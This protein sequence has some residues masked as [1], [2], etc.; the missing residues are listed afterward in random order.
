M[1]NGKKGTILAYRLIPKSLLSR[2]FGSLTRVPLPGGLID[3]IISWYSRKY[4]I[5]DEY[6]TP[7]GGFRTVNEF[8][9]RELRPGS[10]K[11]D[12]S[13]GALVSPVDARVDQFGRITE[14]AVI[15]A[16][17]LDYPA[18]ELVPSEMSRRL[19]K[20]S[21]ITLYLSPG[22]YHRIHSPVQGSIAGFFSIPGTLFTVQDFMVRGLPGLFV[23]NERL[24]TYIE[25][26]NG[27]ISVCKIG[28]M[29]VG[30]ISLSY[31]LPGEKPVITNRT[32]RKRREVLFNPGRQ[33]SVSAGDELARF[34][35]GSTVII[36]TEIPVQFVDIAP[37]R[38]V[39]MGE[40]IGR[41]NGKTG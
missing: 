39:K 32:F 7:P 13:P 10:R 26:S 35:L 22:D 1:M 37:G 40:L 18:E 11:T 12:R 16:K 2:I 34:N 5:I 31:G 24:I 4:G 27:L 29:N 3:R 6:V 25:T 38:K 9:T 41:F 21:F 20:G 14:G 8:F 15:Q 23:K 17:G 28:A 19:R 30:R 33:I 36:L